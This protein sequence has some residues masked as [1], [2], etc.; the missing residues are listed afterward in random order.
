MQI[1]YFGTDW[2][3]IDLSVAQKALDADEFL[4]GKLG[5]SIVAS[6]NDRK[7]A[8]NAD[9]SREGSDDPNFNDSLFVEDD[10]DEFEEEFCA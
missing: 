4:S 6:E 2:L 5:V 9:T 3:Q 1:D 7:E 10:C 8:A